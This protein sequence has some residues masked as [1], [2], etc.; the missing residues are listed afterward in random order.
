MDGP[1]P[2]AGVGGKEGFRDHG[3]VDDDPV[4]FLHSIIF[5]QVRHFACLFVDLA[6][7][8]LSSL[9]DHV[10]DPDQCTFVGMLG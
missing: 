1:D 9:V 5:K 10:R 4:S 2:G 3:H 6:Q 7:S 8:P